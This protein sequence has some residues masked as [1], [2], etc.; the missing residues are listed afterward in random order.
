MFDANIIIV[1]KKSTGRDN[2][3]TFISAPGERVREM[4]VVR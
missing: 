2:I 4:T 3:C 1:G